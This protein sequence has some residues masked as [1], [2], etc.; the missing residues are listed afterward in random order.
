MRVCVCAWEGGIGMQ[1][2]IL[3]HQISVSFSSVVE[4]CDEGTVRLSNQYTYTTYYNLGSNAEEVTTGGLEVCVN[5]TFLQVC[6]SSNVD[7]ALADSICKYYLGYDGQ[8]RFLHVCSMHEIEVA[9][10]F[11]QFISWHSCTTFVC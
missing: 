7:A 3:S 8:S 2:S 1:M 11:V 5:G 9:F 6:N 4:A 10:N